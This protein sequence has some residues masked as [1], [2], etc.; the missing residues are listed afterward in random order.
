MS[1]LSDSAVTALKLLMGRGF[2]LETSL[3]ILLK[4]QLITTEEKYRMLATVVDLAKQRAKKKPRGE[5]QETRGATEMEVDTKVD[6]EARLKEE[7]RKKNEQV[8]KDY[9]IRRK[10][11][12]KPR[13]P[14]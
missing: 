13:E 2:S 7:R 12:D 5:K 14:S 3:S 6:R 10:N 4:A 11:P 8:L 1:F 9:K